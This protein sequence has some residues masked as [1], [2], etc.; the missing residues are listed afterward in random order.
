MKPSDTRGKPG[1]IVLVRGGQPVE[2]WDQIMGHQSSRVGV[3]QPGSMGLIV[4]THVTAWTYVLWSMPCLV[5]WVHDGQ[6][7]RV[8]R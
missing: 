6:L 1:E 7:R 5:G 8:V 4:A 2:V 3:V